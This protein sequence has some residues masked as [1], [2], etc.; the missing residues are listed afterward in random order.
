M[1]VS[2]LAC[3]TQH[4]SAGVSFALVSHVAILKLHSPFESG[5]SQQS[6][7]SQKTRRGDGTSDK[8]QIRSGIIK[9]LGEEAEAGVM[10][11]GA[12]KSPTGCGIGWQSFSGGRWREGGRESCLALWG[13]RNQ[14]FLSLSSF[15][16]L[17][18]LGQDSP[19]LSQVI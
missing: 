5:F 18:L 2:G 13:F 6:W 3:T 19:R 11:P 9:R 17:R 8:N 12:L 4:V 15:R 14:L 1:G 7:G 10:G 16:R